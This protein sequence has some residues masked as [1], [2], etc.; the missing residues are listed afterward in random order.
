M[1]SYSDFNSDVGL[2][3]SSLLPSTQKLFHATPSELLKIYP[4]NVIT[5][6]WKE[7]RCT[8]VNE[9]SIEVRLHQIVESYGNIGTAICF[10]YD[11]VYIIP[12]NS[13]IP[14]AFNVLF[15]DLIYLRWDGSE[16]I[17]ALS[18]GEKLFISE[19]CIKSAD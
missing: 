12:P 17:I 6:R 19:P 8:I 9:R 18:D 2:L 4:T 13:S 7:Q 3:K 5:H 14:T 16:E 1:E 11:N 10:S 15:S